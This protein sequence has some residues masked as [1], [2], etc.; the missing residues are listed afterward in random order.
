[1]ALGG[2]RFDKNNE[3][4]RGL[5]KDNLCF[6]DVLQEQQVFLI[7]LCLLSLEYY[8][9]QH[10]YRT[11]L[12]RIKVIHNCVEYT[13]ISGTTRISRS[14][15]LHLYSCSI[16]ICDNGEWVT[17]P[18]YKWG[19]EKWLV[20][21][22]GELKKG[23][24]HKVT[25]QWRWLGRFSRWAMLACVKECW[26]PGFSYRLSGH[27]SCPPRHFP[28]AHYTLWASTLISFTPKPY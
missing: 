24:L 28:P 23:M 11:L 4:S 12:K 13:A 8:I 25:E 22:S 7:Y 21:M 1:M 9:R 2:V 3:E 10:P 14:Y 26:A 19:I 18:S 5:L 27:V 15:L 16:L 17:W 20:V 6:V